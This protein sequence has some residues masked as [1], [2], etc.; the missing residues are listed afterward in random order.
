MESVLNNGLIP[1]EYSNLADEVAYRRPPANRLFDQIYMET[2]D[3]INQT[4]FM[5]QYV[6]GKDVIFLGDGDGMSM[7]FGL[8]GKE[9]IINAPKTM[10]V[11]DFDQRI[12]NN[13]ANFS[14]EF[15]FDVPINSR[16]YNVIEPIPQ[17]LKQKFDFFYIN[18][19]YGSKNMGESTNVWLH[20]C[21]DLC[22]DK[23]EGCIVI[24]YDSTMEWTLTAMK[25][26]QNFLIAN[27][28]VIR[29]MVSYM[30][31]YHLKDNPSLKSAT[32]I[33][34]RISP[35]KSDYEDKYLPMELV[36][37]LYGRPRN[38]PKYIM[39]DETRLGEPDFNWVYGTDLA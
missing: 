31:R 3:M 19:P 2:G 14:K 39:E 23:S 26:I 8:F 18:P 20:R 38:I 33:V 35:K 25:N 16:L 32:L 6:A 9:E 27:G 7:M 37:H 12:V 22:N 34:E 10:T 28:F 11:I 4:L 17:D 5:A 1:Y 36:K 24:P 13:V 29:D 30:H 21:M 15:A